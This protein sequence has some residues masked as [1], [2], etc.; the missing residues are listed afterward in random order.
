MPSAN[1]GCSRFQDGRDAEIANIDPNFHP[2]T[3]PNGAGGGEGA[4]G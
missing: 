4:F 1:K 2:P 3:V